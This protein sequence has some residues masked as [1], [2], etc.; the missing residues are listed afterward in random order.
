LALNHCTKENDFF[1]NGYL[2]TSQSLF[3][4]AKTDKKEFDSILNKMEQHIS[5]LLQIHIKKLKTD[6][7]K[8]NSFIAIENIFYIIQKP[9]FELYP[10]KNSHL[11]KLM[12]GKKVEL[13]YFDRELYRLKFMVKHH[14]FCSAIDYTGAIGPVEVTVLKD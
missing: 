4:V 11:I 1:I 3:L 5:L 10:L 2:I 14:S 13:L 9:L 8:I 7:Y 12:T 6:R